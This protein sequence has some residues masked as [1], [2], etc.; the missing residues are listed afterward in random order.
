MIRTRGLAWQR[1]MATI[2]SRPHLAYRD[3]EFGNLFSSSTPRSG[4]PS[5]AGEGIC[6]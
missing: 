3:S 1:S 2:R 4:E 6:R 5:P